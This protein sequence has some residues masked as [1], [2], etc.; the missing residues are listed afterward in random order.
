MPAGPT[1]PG[2]GRH[3]RGLPGDGGTAIGVRPRIVVIVLVSCERAWNWSLSD[4][5][6]LV[7]ACPL[8]FAGQGTRPSAR[9]AVPLLG[10]RLV[11][12]SFVVLPGHGHLLLSGAT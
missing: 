4:R 6:R 1:R 5:A 2:D 10:R 12:L 3:P 7:A 8:G 11:C 9:S